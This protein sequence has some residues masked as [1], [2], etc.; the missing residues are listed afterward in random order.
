MSDRA[1]SIVVAAPPSTRGEDE[2]LMCAFAAGDAD[3]FDSLYERYRALVYRF[4]ARQLRPEDAQEAHQETWL[5]IIKAR[6]RYQP[7][8]AFRSYL[9]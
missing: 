2:A 4:F 8:A 9:F 6:E 3:A 7:N 5:R 1:G